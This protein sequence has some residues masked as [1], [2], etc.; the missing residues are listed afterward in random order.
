MP[1]F[2]STV[3]PARST[4]SLAVWLLG[5]LCNL[6]ILTISIPCVCEGTWALNHSQ[7]HS[8]P[9]YSQNEVTTSPQMASPLT[10][11]PAD[12][13]L[14]TSAIRNPGDNTLHVVSLGH[15]G[16]LCRVIGKRQDCPNFVAAPKNKL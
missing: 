16:I 4:E 2:A 15:H 14:P 6:V 10:Y 3:E 5:A 11:F 8:L 1:P 12:L 9:F 13:I 7:K